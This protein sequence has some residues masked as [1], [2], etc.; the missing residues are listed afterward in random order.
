MN[1]IKVFH[2]RKTAAQYFFLISICFLSFSCKESLDYPS[3]YIVMFSNQYFENL[4]SVEISG[5]IF[6]NIE[7]DSEITIKHLIYGKHTINIITKS[8]LLISSILILNGTKPNV[9]VVLTEEGLLQL[10]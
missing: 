2:G 6:E 9:H 4:D 10:K 1:T 8:K 3:E 5:N 7:V